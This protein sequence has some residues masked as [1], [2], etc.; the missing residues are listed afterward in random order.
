MSREKRMQTYMV[1]FRIIALRFP[2]KTWMPLAFP[3]EFDAD[4]E[5]LNHK[6]SAVH[7]NTAINDTRK[8]HREAGQFIEIG[9]VLLGGP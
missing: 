2:D 6:I 4:G 9:R 5:Y 8:L 1:R 7:E 3:I